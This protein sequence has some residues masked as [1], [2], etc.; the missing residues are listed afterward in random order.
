MSSSLFLVS[1]A[2]LASEVSADFWLGHYS[3]SYPNGFRGVPGGIDR[4]G[5]CSISNSPDASC[6]DEGIACDWYGR[7]G[8]SNFPNYCGVQLKCD[9]P[10]G[11]S[12]VHIGTTQARYLY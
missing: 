3:V 6:D 2:A 10:A 12:V 9:W 8:D 4:S 1:L 7:G 5:G 11:G